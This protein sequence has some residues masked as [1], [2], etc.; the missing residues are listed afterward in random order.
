MSENMLFTLGIILYFILNY[1]YWYIGY[2]LVLKTFFSAPVCLIPD[3][4]TLV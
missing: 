3:I 1:I 2:S 4:Y